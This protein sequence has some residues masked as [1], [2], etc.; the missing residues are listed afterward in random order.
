VTRQEAEAR[1]FI[2]VTTEERTTAPILTAQG[3]MTW[4][5]WCE[6]EVVRLAGCRRKAAVVQVGRRCSVWAEPL[7]PARCAVK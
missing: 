4:S 7:V 6:Q 5:S 2:A 3:E 1:G